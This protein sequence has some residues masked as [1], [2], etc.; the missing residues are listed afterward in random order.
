MT[1]LFLCL[2]LLIPFVCCGKGKRSPSKSQIKTVKH[3]LKTEG[4]QDPDA[5][6]SCDGIENGTL[7]LGSF[8][9]NWPGATYS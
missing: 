4:I 9:L 5:S 1:R 8:N 7:K 6:I 2:A 3:W